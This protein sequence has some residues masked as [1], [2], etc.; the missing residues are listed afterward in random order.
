MGSMHPE[1]LTQSEQDKVFLQSFSPNQLRERLS[2]IGGSD[3]AIIANGDYYGKTPHFLWEVKTGRRGW[4]DLS[5]NLAVAMGTHTEPLNRFWFSKVT[6]LDVG[7]DNCSMVRHPEYPFIGCNADGRVKHPGGA[8]S[9]FE[10]KHIS[11]YSRSDPIET[12]FPQ[13]QHNMMVMG[14][15]DAYL[16]IF[17]DNNTHYFH[18]VKRNEKYQEELLEKEIEFWTYV[19]RDIPP[20]DSGWD[21][22][23]PPMDIIRKVDM[24]GNNR[25][26]DHAQT[27][28]ESKPYYENH[29]KAT[30][31]IKSMVEPNVQECA[32]HGISA[33]RDKQGRLRVYE[34]K[35]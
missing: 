12:Y 22:T 19:E 8:E 28:L 16:S 24:E 17:K 26:A 14:M 31:T 4:E 32:G 11:A 15:E 29:M 34:E 23:T 3:A 2:F 9:V 1:Q 33:R 35:H 7:M 10:A 13:L 21:P 30:K 5:D 27:W 18:R 6:G 25:W 20:P